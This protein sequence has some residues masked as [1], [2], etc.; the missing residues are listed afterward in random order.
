MTLTERQRQALATRDLSVDLVRTACVLAVV[1][2]HSLMTGL[3]QG[4]DGGIVWRNELQEQAWFP[5]ASWFGQL[6]PLFFVLGGFAGWQGWASVQRRGGTPR[7]FV[8]TR[9]LRL[10]TPLLVWYLGVG[11]LVLGAVALGVPAP[12]A[13][14]LA[15]GVGMPLWFLAA[16]LITQ[17]A[18]PMLV[19]AHRARP[20]LTAGLLLAACVAVDAARFGSGVPAIG[21]LNL[22][23][24]WPLVQQ[25]GFLHADGTLAAL[26]RRTLVLVAVAAFAGVGLLAEAGPYSADMLDD[27]NPPTLPLVLVGVGQTALFVLAKPALDALMRRRPV[28]IGVALAGTRLMTIYLWH[29]LVVILVA[30]AFLVAPGVLPEAGTGAWWWARIPADLVVFGVL[31]VIAAGVARFER[32]PRRLG[33]RPSRQAIAAAVVL[34][35]VPPFWAMEFGLDLVGF[36]WGAVLVGAAVLLARGRAEARGLPAGPAG[37]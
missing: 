21:L 33:R 18:L 7:D 8:R 26:R 11:A 2:L 4:Q 37:R 29:L 35:V 20:L 34:A 13:A 24:V 10:A 23:F 32:G 17:A 31:L 16:Y 14:Q 30:A 19:R 25:L 22:L 9:V 6:M 5:V 28:Q 36:V 15:R 27:L 12:V 3:T 1:V